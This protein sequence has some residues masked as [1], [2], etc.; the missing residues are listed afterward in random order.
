MVGSK[1]LHEGLP[2]RVTP[3][4]DLTWLCPNFLLKLLTATPGRPEAARRGCISVIKF[5]LPAEIKVLNGTLLWE[6]M[7]SRN[8]ISE[9]FFCRA[10]CSGGSGRAWTRSP[11]SSC[12]PPRCSPRWSGRTPCCPRKECEQEDQGK[13]REEEGKAGGRGRLRCARGLWCSRRCLRS[14]C[15][16]RLW[17]RS[18]RCLWCSSRG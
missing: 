15:R 13:E 6:E 9:K 4:V 5:K 17:I 12:R 18:C 16:C 3:L 11:R 2:G 1:G 8:K 10:H 7:P 14:S